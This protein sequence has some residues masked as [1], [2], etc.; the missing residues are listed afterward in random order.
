MQPIGG[1]QPAP[2]APLP[3]APDPGQPEMLI[4]NGVSYGGRELL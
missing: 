4:Y 3:S 2:D 1:N